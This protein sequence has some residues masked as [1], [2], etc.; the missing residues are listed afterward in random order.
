MITTIVGCNEIGS[1]K[2]DHELDMIADTQG[3]D[4]GNTG[5]ILKAGPVEGWPGRLPKHFPDT[6][7]KSPVNCETCIEQRS[8]DTFGMA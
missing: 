3:R 4:A 8:L 5:R 1:P 6:T 2:R 7:G